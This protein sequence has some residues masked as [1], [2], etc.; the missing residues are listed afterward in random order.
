MIMAKSRKKTYSIKR[1]AGEIYGGGANGRLSLYKLKRQYTPVELFSRFP[2]VILK[3]QHLDFAYGAPFP[4]TFDGLFTEPALYMP[5]GTINEIIWGI[6]RSAM[7]G[8]ELRGFLVLQSAFERSLLLDDHQVAAGYIEEIHSK[9]GASLW[10]AQAILSAAE[11]GS[12][13]N[14]LKTHI[15]SA[16]ESLGQNSITGFMLTYLTRR[17]ESRGTKT[18]LKDE[19]SARLANSDETFKRYA[20]ERITDVTAIGQDAVGTLLL[21]EAQASLIDHYEMLIVCLRR[22]AVARNLPQPVIDAVT[23]PLGLL[24]KRTSDRRL[25]PILRTL[26]IPAPLN[27]SSEV[28]RGNVFE[29]YSRSDYSLAMTLGAQHLM[30]EDATDAPVLALMARA[31]V[32]AGSAAVPAMSPTLEQLCAHLVGV[33]SGIDSAYGDATYIFSSCDKNYGQTW[34]LYLRC[35]VSDCLSQ[36]V[37]LW[38]NSSLADICVHDVYDSPLALMFAR[39]KAAEELEQELTQS[40]HYKLTLGSILLILRGACDES[41]RISVRKKLSYVGRHQL[42]RGRFAEA[43]ELLSGHLDEFIPEHSF[44]ILTAIALACAGSN[45]SDKAANALVEAYIANPRIPTALPLTAVTNCLVKEEDWPQS[46]EVPIALELYNEFCSNDQISQLRYCFERFQETHQIRKPVDLV[47]KFDEFSRE[48]AILYLDRVW[49]PEVMRQTLLYNGSD[50]IEEARISVCRQLATVD[51]KESGTYLEEIRERVKRQEIAKGT[52][53]VEQSK[54]Y[55]DIAAIKKG[56]KAKIGGQY[57]RYKTAATG[58]ADAG[59]DVIAN[60]ANVLHDLSVSRKQSIGKILSHLHLLDDSS[61]TEVDGQFD[62]IF[63]EVTNEFLKGD[64]GLNAY[65]STRVRH[66]TLSNT[67]RKPVADERLVTTRE[68]AG[69]GYNRNEFWDSKLWLLQED[70]RESV[71]AALDDFTQGFDD[72]VNL[73]KD[74]YIQIKVTHGVSDSRDNPNALFIYRSSNLERRF[75]QRFV[76]T[77]NSIDDFIDVCIDSLWEKT[78]AN[79]LGVQKI[80]EQDVRADFMKTF[81]KLTD[82]IAHVPPC[83]ALSDLRNA[84]SKARTNIQLKIK[85]VSS[86]FTRRQVYDR[87]DYIP[88]LPIDIA[89]N[90]ISK[91]MP[92]NSVMPNVKKTV[93]SGESVKMPGRTLDGIVDAFYGVLVNAMKHSGLSGNDLQVEITLNFSESRFVARIESSVASHLPTETD[94]SKIA[95]IR[96]TLEKTDS[97]HK[98]QIEGGS[99][100]HK[101]WRSINSPFYSDPKLN[102]YFSMEKTFVVEISFS[103]ETI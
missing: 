66:G 27:T 73:L 9:F 93:S 56:L 28:S 64:H 17:A 102:F 36:D 90:M 78:D 92:E 82:A 38:R 83:Q 31:R 20:E 34:A 65:L 70:Q 13:R 22:L 84:I 2:K 94:R 62:S 103:L 45:D 100:L 41:E 61:D 33:F 39:G 79:L 91:T 58:Q 59:D 46:I 3:R 55:V 8:D 19:I 11:S 24:Y 43:A 48:K 74:G 60:L 81:D 42:D 25:V 75:M 14:D 23:R 86:W 7:F 89:L 87:Q 1:A 18:F 5:A 98:A 54:V 16:I 30:L 77:L 85:E 47:A 12:P 53:L 80:I 95:Q 44:W 88:S 69:A 21:Y 101:L 35:V 40:A 72:I 96:D 6:C 57:T 37:S 52:S 29:A 68:Q 32:R 4:E 76:K 63:T 67:L 97:R 26:G 50:E 10:L 49:T 99:G 15:T 71:L 51:S